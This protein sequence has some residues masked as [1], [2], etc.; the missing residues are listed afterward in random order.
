MLKVERITSELA[1]TLHI[2][3]SCSEM[4]KLQAI[5]TLVHTLSQLYQLKY[6]ANRKLC[7]TYRHTDT[8]TYNYAELYILRLSIL[9]KK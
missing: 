8:Q 2:R 7:K 6:L 3:L 9:N 5:E 4:S 1:N